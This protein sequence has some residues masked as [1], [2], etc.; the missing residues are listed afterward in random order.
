[1]AILK[2]FLLYK[3]LNGVQKVVS[4]NLTAPTIFYPGN[5]DAASMFCC[6]PTFGRWHLQIIKTEFVQIEFDKL[7]LDESDNWVDLGE[8]KWGA[9]TSTPALVSELEAKVGK[10][11]NP[12]NATLGRSCS[13]VVPF[14]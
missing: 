11:P 14:Y 9:V 12:A 1:M 13:P 10:Y 2:I 8:C 4:S 3:S 5:Q 6:F 7:Q